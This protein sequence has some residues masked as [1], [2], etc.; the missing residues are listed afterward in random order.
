MEENLPQPKDDPKSFPIFM[1]F[2]RNVLH[3]MFFYAWGEP[4]EKHH[5]I[6]YKTA[7]TLKKK[8]L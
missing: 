3:I 6:F 8:C 2:G 5:H 1:K 4:F 7:K